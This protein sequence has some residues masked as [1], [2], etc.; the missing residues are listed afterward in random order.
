V[1][2]VPDRIYP[3]RLVLLLTLASS[4]YA[5]APDSHAFF[6][7]ERAA[8]G[9]DA[10]LRITAVRLNG[11]VS[12][13]DAPGTFADI[14]DHRN[15][16]WYRDVDTG[17][18][19]DLSGF[20]G[21]PWVAQ[22]GIVTAI[23]LPSL[24]ADAQTEA[25]TARDGWWNSADSAQMTMLPSSPGAAGADIVRVTP[26]GGS[27][28][29]VWCDRN[30][31]LITRTV[32]HNDDGDLTTSYSDWREVG[33]VR[34]PFRR[35]QVDP[36]GDSTTYEVRSASLE[37][38]IDPRKLARPKPEP[39]GVLAAGK[40]V[41]I[42]FRLTAFDR[43]HIV[44]AATVN[45]RPVSLLFDTGA[46][47][48]FPPA[49]AQRLGLPTG[50]GVNLAGVAGGGVSGGF[51]Q[52]NEI[53]IGGAA[54]KDEQAIVGPLPYVA[55]HPRAGMQVD[56][57]T[58]FEFLAEFRTTIDYPAR[59]LSFAPLGGPP[60]REGV[61]LPFLSDDHNIYVEAAIGGATGL[62]RLDTG[63]R[64]GVTV[65]R[66]FAETH[67]LF[68]SGGHAN[69]LSGGLGGVLKTREFAGATFI[70]AGSTFFSVPVTVSEAASGSFVS[71]AIAGNLGAAL[72]D[73]F[74]ITV[75]YRAHTLTFLPGPDANRPFQTDQAGLS[76]TQKDSEKITVLAVA[77]NSP[78]AEAGIRA[79][80]AITQ[81]Q[82]I[83]V[84]DRG[85]GVFDLSPLILGKKPFVLMV[86][87]NDRLFQVNVTP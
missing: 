26:A 83:S 65:F 58:G 40:P 64:G 48:Y 28:I 43:G 70:L 39:H 8:I 62:F 59:T 30:T 67:R 14:I 3:L 34:V 1:N 36:S 55:M 10:W 19:Q 24:I 33:A 47:N 49:K 61:T 60:P 46:A 45:G 86:M 13:G 20:D 15:G 29:D 75:D 37:T 69:I 50:G 18:R 6:Q 38:T 4:A 66:A 73:R 57:L 68:Q 27:P 22:N 72:L 9:G 74:R 63:D 32:A 77:P 71:R 41:T 78:A 82:G 53:A 12:A 44:T 52:A 2:I 16:H 81:V 85:L 31:H 7:A 79:G 17:P 80:D 23:D 54:L 5:A 35:V 42:P 87:R 25:F 84:R 76:V 21:R 51:A 56:G 11:V